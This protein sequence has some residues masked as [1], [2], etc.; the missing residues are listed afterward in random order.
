MLEKPLQCKGKKQPRRCQCR[1]TDVTAGLADRRWTVKELLYY[2]LAW[3][4]FEWGELWWNG[5]RL[6]HSRAR[7]CRIVENG[8]TEKTVSHSGWLFS[9]LSARRRSGF[10]IHLHR[11]GQVLLGSGSV[12]GIEDDPNVIGHIGLHLLT[13]Y[14]KAA[15]M[16]TRIRSG[17]ASKPDRQSVLLT[18]THPEKYNYRWRFWCSPFFGVVTIRI[19]LA[20]TFC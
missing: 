15:L 11:S 12:G 2:S 6:P 20:Y 1:R 4:G 17:S 18:L 13:R 19:Q 16:T 14:F 10:A 3:L 8:A 7:F 5:K 9:I